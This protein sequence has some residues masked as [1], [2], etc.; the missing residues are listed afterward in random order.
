MPDAPVVL[1]VYGTL[2]PGHLRWPMLEPHAVAWRDTSVAGRLYDTGNGWPAA[3]LGGG[4]D[5]VPGAV[6][7]LSADR[8]E[9]L[10]AV[11]D[12]A[13]GVPDLFVRIRVETLAGDHAWAYSR[14]GPVAG[15]ARIERW[16][17]QLER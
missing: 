11:L 13:E 15:L 2:L 9:Q 7:E 5:R 16:S 1:F 6:V 14:P 4:S 8:A 10:L 3:V 12:E 17:H